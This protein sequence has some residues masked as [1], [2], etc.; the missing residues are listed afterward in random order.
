MLAVGPRELPDDG[1]VRVW[2]DHGSGAGHEITVPVRH[3]VLAELDNGSGTTAIY[4]LGVLHEVR[5]IMTGSRTDPMIDIAQAIAN[6]F[7][8]IGFAFVEDQHLEALAGALRAFLE[9]RKIPIDED[10]AAEYYGGLEEP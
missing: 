8:H 7:G 2:V 6:M 1:M 4:A 5:R 10:R 9:A 3:L